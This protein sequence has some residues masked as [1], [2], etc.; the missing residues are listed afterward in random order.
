[1]NVHLCLGLVSCDVLLPARRLITTITAN[2]AL[3]VSQILADNF[4]NG[5]LMVTYASI[6]TGPQA[7]IPSSPYQQGLGLVRGYPVVHKAVLLDEVHVMP[8]PFCR[9]GA[10]SERDGSADGSP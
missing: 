4:E 9:D 8:Y 5:I 6:L 1:M 7:Q 10:L 3:S 2:N